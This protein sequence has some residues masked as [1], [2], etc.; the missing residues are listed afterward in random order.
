MVVIKSI[1]TRKVRLIGVHFHN[2]HNSLSWNVT[3]Q[4]Q[5]SLRNGKLTYN[6]PSKSTLLCILCLNL[7]FV[8]QFQNNIGKQKYKKIEDLEILSTSNRSS[9]KFLFSSSELYAHFAH[10]VQVLKTYDVLFYHQVKRP[11]GVCN[12]LEWGLQNKASINVLILL[13]LV[14]SRQ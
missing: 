1:S 10:I 8:Q 5:D 11:F 3:E 9:T 13:S 4:L 7:Y 12:K 2:F 14:N 6:I